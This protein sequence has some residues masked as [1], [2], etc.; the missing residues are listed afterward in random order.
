MKETFV[1]NILTIYIK[2]A[3]IIFGQKTSNRPGGN[4]PSKPARMGRLGHG[5]RQEGHHSEDDSSRI[6]SVVRKIKT[7]SH[8]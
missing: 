1:T 5:D 8:R 2:H 4:G 3:I 7:I 6:Y